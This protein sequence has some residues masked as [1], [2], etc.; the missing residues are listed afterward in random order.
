M[1]P[2]VICVIF[3]ILCLLVEPLIQYVVNSFRSKNKEGEE[4]LKETQPAQRLHVEDLPAYKQ[5]V[6]E[7]GHRHTVTHKIGSWAQNNYL[8]SVKDSKNARKNSD[9]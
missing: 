1:T 4:E 3:L 6:Q 7:L 9:S 2:V 5:F 8:Q